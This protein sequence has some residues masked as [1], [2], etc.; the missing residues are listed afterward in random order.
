VGPETYSHSWTTDTDAI[1]AEDM[2]SQ[3]DLWLSYWLE[4]Q[5]WAG[6][7][8]APGEVPLCKP[9]MAQQSWEYEKLISSSPSLRI[10]FQD[11]L[12]S[13][14]EDLHADGMISNDNKTEVMNP[15]TPSPNRASKLVDLVTNRVKV[16]KEDYQTFVALLRRN[17]RAYKP[18]LVIRKFVYVIACTLDD[19][20]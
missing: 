4:C 17:Q 13:L 3:T 14:S 10:A 11:Q 8:K 2:P 18:I 5:L 20:Y 1:A 15:S 9:K 16:M 6:E 12:I 19:F 7:G